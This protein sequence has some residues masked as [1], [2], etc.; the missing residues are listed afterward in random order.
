VLP[1]PELLP[2]EPL[3]EGSQ[4]TL[5]CKAPALCPGLPPTLSW[6]PL[7]GDEVY[8]WEENENGT[9]FVSSILNF[10][11]SCLHHK[12]TVTCT[13]DYNL[14][15]DISGR[16]AEERVSL[17]V[18]YSPKNTTA[19]FSPSGPVEEGALVTLQC[20]SDGNPPVKNYTWFQVQGDEV[21]LRATGK[22]FTICMTATT[23]GFYYCEAQNQHGT[24]IS[25]TLK[26]I[27]GGEKQ[28]MAQSQF[29][30]SF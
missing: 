28:K 27:L 1:K 30:L 21:T 26:L 20:T 22:N 23:A 24:Q 16:E 4:L 11:I 14:E 25:S 8:M 13:A 2:V 17:N 15:K 19:F 5:T 6:T 12:Q 18:L 9:M 3:K 7:L 29:L 10:T